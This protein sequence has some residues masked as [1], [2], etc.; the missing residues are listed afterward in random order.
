MSKIMEQKT[1]VY[2]N[3]SIKQHAKY[4]IMYVYNAGK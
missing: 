1:E 3:Y 2:N 4:M